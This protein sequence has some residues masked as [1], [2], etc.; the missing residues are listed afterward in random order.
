MRQSDKTKKIHEYQIPLK[1][2]KQI[3]FPLSIS[4]TELMI[5]A[6]F[7]LHPDLES[8][9]KDKIFRVGMYF[10]S[11]DFSSITKIECV[12]LFRDLNDALLYKLTWF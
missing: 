6:S 12:I 11:D 10:Q 8:W 2:I 1:L 4:S 7:T 9:L 5:A 3:E